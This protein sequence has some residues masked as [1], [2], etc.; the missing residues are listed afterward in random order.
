MLAEGL[1]LA[2]SRLNGTV[3]RLRRSLLV[4]VLVS[5]LA[6]TAYVAGIIAVTLVVA[7]TEGMVVAASLVCAAT[8]C[9][10]ILILIVFMAIERRER[11]LRVLRAGATASAVQASL[12]GGLQPDLPRMVRESPIATTLMVAFLAYALT[13][14][15]RRR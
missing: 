11:R 12:M 10:A 4:C 1:W 8:A 9:A 2:R 3:A 13:K 14:G 6:L 7:R 5:I 15:T